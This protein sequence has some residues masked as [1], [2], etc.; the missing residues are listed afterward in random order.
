M[1]IT[2][3]NTSILEHKSAALSA[4]TNALKY[5]Q[6]PESYDRI[7][8]MASPIVS[9][10]TSQELVKTLKE[11]SLEVG[12]LHWADQN[13]DDKK[14]LENL[15]VKMI[16]LLDKIKSEEKFDKS[17]VKKPIATRISEH[18][19]KALNAFKKENDLEMRY[20]PV[21]K[22]QK[23][24]YLTNRVPVA[25]FEDFVATTT[26]SKSVQMYSETIPMQ[27]STVDAACTIGQRDY[28][29][30]RFVADTFSFCAN[31]NT[32]EAEVFG[33]LDGHGGTDT[34]NFVK[35]NFSSKLKAQLE[36]RFIDKDID[37]DSICYALKDVFEEFQKELRVKGVKDGT[38]AV[39][40]FKLA[41]SDQLWVA[42]VGDSRAYLNRNG[43]VIPM[44][45][46][47]KPCL[48]K[49]P[50]LVA[51]EYANQLFNRGVTLSMDDKKEFPELLDQKKMVMSFIQE[52]KD[53]YEM[54]MGIPG[55]IHLDMA[56]SLGDLGF[57]QWKKHTPEI[58]AQKVQKGDQLIM[59]SDGVL[60]PMSTVVKNAQKDK[61]N[62]FTPKETA[63]CLVQSSIKSGD[64]ITAVVVSF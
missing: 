39:I 43:N 31:N 11:R 50:S 16:G 7:R 59:H 19:Q 40:G 3:S 23:D 46:D 36:K 49:N 20:Y 54:Q 4:L 2:S 12:A 9:A 53:R 61:V 44:S 51:N 37:D 13:P 26:D 47:Q 22:Q 57:D 34:V 63:E 38:T 42:N 55:K 24:K 32:F 30:D 27:S 14:A 6:E 48:F 29:E 10:G 35:N 60:A 15:Y 21:T 33:V 62:G 8:Q 28:M 18:N 64:N 25:A 41:I 1:S 17:S 52:Q 56:R 45:I 58:F 5:L